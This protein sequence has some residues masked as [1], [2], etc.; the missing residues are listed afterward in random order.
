V[1][2]SLADS[3]SGVK[4]ATMAEERHVGGLGYLFTFVALV[5]LATLSLG[6]SFLHWTTGDLVVSLV[7]ATIKAALVL[8]IFMHLVEQRFSSHVVV[9]VTALMLAL[10]AGLTAADVATRQTSAPSPRPEPSDL[11]YRH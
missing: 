11:F 6:L 4:E 5:A 2:L 1:D 10:L 9:G 7:I 8:Y 3:L